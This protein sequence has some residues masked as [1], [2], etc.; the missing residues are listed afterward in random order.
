MVR[1]NDLIGIHKPSCEICVGRNPYINALYWANV[2][3]STLEVYG[4][5]TEGIALGLRV[6][7]LSVS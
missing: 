1:L 5:R 7:A 2:P 3:M 6:E 4:R